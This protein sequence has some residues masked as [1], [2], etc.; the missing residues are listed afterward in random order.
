ML[1]TIVMLTLLVLSNALAAQAAMI[2]KDAVVARIREQLQ[3]ILL[4]Q[5]L[6][7]QLLNM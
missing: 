3:A 5:M 6:R 2:E 1:K 4:W 7:V